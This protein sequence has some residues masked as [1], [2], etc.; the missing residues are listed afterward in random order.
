VENAVATGTWREQTSPTGY[1][2]GAVYHGTLQ[3]VVD[4]AGRRMNGM[5]LGFGRDF[6][7]NSGQWELTW[8]EALTSKSSQRAYHDKV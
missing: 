6:T 4:P 7:I 3:V 5:W 8:C 1:Y 2:K